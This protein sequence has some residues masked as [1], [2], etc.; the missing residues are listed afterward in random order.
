MTDSSSDILFKTIQDLQVIYQQQPNNLPAMRKEVLRCLS[1][2][3]D[4][5]QVILCSKVPFFKLSEDQLAGQVQASAPEATAFILQYKDFL[6]NLYSRSLQQDF[7]PLAW[8]PCEEAEK[9]GLPTQSLLLAPICMAQECFATILLL[10]SKPFEANALE[11]IRLLLP[12]ISIILHKPLPQFPV[13]E[14]V[15]F[16]ELLDSLPDAVWSMDIAKAR[17]HYLSAACESIFGYTAEELQGFTPKD[18]Q[19][20]I[21]PEDYPLVEAAWEKVMQEGYAQVEFRIRRKDGTIRYLFDKYQLVRNDDGVLRR[22]NGITRDITKR[23]TERLRLEV[24]LQREQELN[25]ELSQKEEELS[26]SEEE[27]RQHLHETSRYNEFLEQTRTVLKNSEERYRYLFEHSPVPMWI[28]ERQSL[29]FL[30]ANQAVINLYGYT[31]AEFLQM[32][33]KDICSEEARQEFE[34]F[35][36]QQSGDNPLLQSTGYW[37]HQRKDGTKVTVEVVVSEI[38]LEDQEANLTL[39][40]D[41]SEKVNSQRQLIES[42]AQF[43]SMFD[44]SVQAYC[45]ID[46]NYRLLK[47]NKLTKVL[48]QKYFK[49]ELQEGESFLEYVFGERI[50]VFKENFARALQ[51]ESIFLERNISLH[52]QDIFFEIQY[53]PIYGM[54]KKINSV[55][56]VYRDV[57]AQRQNEILLQKHYRNSKNF[58][59]A[60]NR[61]AVISITDLEGTI[62]DVNRAFCQLSKF[63]KR[64]VIGKKHSIV[65]A[66]IHDAAFF[67]EMWA[68]LCTGKS[69]RGEICNRAKDGTLYW[70]EM[71]INPIQDESG[72]VYQYLAVSYPISQ[73]KRAEKE[74]QE[75]LER[76]AHYAFM[77]SHNLRRPLAN[78][79]GLVSLFNSEDAEFDQKI[80]EKIRV[81]AFELDKIVHAMN[82]LL[83]SNELKNIDSF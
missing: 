71:I 59:N 74:K 57:S 70:L 76:L 42:E 77:N 19:K 49:K 21:L 56:F 2:F 40:L 28:Y 6:E 75:L 14:E 16:P 61:S 81:S 55:A 37:E 35:I 38:L 20:I 79:L 33:L 65:S 53:L 80:I 72:Q 47:V 12:T 1:N 45:L 73:R 63:S 78:I 7:A 68:K 36:Q 10:N 54:D 62:L 31:E 13:Q 15:S 25:E 24:A 39:V 23:K 4:S 9:K 11:N 8:S 44:A 3:F 67:E 34:R 66:Q 83:R 22:V 46:Q 32:T 50:E 30:A 48:A 60:L 5:P 64:E 41:V 58:R 18:W 51:G 29:R 26:A 69:W 17:Y 52:G 82:D 27:I 43:R